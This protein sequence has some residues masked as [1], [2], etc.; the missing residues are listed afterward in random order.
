MKIRFIK[1]AKSA[2]DV[3]GAESM[4]MTP[5]TLK[6]PG[7]HMFLKA[8]EWESIEI[9]LTEEIPVGNLK[10][11]HMCSDNII[12]KFDTVSGHIVKL[13]CELYPEKAGAIRKAHMMK[14][15]MHAVLS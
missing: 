14:E 12:V 5:D 10:Y 13:L 8:H 6:H 9:E 11:L 7:T 4:E 2:I 15:D 1:D 3:E